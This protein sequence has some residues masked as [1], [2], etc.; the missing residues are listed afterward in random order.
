MDDKEALAALTAVVQKG[1]MLDKALGDGMAVAKVLSAIKSVTG[2]LQQ[3]MS[4]RI[5]LEGIVLRVRQEEQQL[6]LAANGYS[7]RVAKL[8]AEAAKA[9]EV[10]AEAQKKMAAGANATPLNILAKA[11]DFVAHEKAGFSPDS[12]AVRPERSG[13]FGNSD[14]IG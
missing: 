13:R 9:L 7:E 3:K 14:R 1:A 8:N 2:L 11:L 6:K 5:G 4:A 10:I 12:V